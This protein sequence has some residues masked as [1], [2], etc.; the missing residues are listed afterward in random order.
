M[1][2]I[3]LDGEAVAADI[4]ADLATRIERLKADGVTPGLGTLLVGDDG[5]SANYVAMKHRDAAELGIEAK[6]L[7]LPAYV[8][9]HDATL[10]EI[11]TRQ[12][13]GDQALTGAACWRLLFWLRSARK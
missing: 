2:A 7:G 10:A 3:V 1:T 8:V 4:K 12:P 13:R 5:P 9:L 6:R 11:A